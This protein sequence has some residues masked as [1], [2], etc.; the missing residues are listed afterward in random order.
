M[1]V[2]GFCIEIGTERHGWARGQDAGRRSF[3][4]EVHPLRTSGAL[5]QM[6]S[7]RLTQATLARIGTRPARSASNQRP[8][9]P[10][11]QRRRAPG[12]VHPLPCTSPAKREAQRI[13]MKP[14]RSS[15][16]FDRRASI[17]RQWSADLRRDGAT[18]R[19]WL[20]NHTACPN[21]GDIVSRTPL[22][23]PW[24]TPPPLPNAV[25]VVGF[26]AQPL[27]HLLQLGQRN[28]ERTVEFRGQHSPTRLFEHTGATQ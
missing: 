8:V 14:R 11:R 25:V 9:G 5:R 2:E 18:S 16:S 6:R 21:H 24:R 19:P 3:V 28:I 23:T 17:I 22:K 10:P 20:I 1:L 26:G 4:A 12:P 7:P 13:E 27:Q 15:R